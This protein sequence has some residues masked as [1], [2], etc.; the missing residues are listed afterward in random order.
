MRARWIALIACGL[1]ALGSIHLSRADGQ[2]PPPPSP[3]AVFAWSEQGM[4]STHE[5]FSSICLMPLGTT[6]RTQV[7]V[8]GD[9]PEI[10]D[11]DVT[12]TY[13]VPTH[14]RSFDKTN[15]WTHAQQ[16]F[17]VSLAPDIGRTGHGL[18]GTMTTTPG[19]LWQVTGVPVV[20]IDNAGRID[21]YPVGLVKVTGNL[22]VGESR[23]V[24]GV[25]GE[26]N[27]A[28]CHGTGTGSPSIGVLQYHD[29]FEGTD[30]MNQQPVFCA[31]CH[32]DTS[33]G[34]PGKPGISTLSHAMH[35]GML[36]AVVQSG[37]EN[38]C[39]ACHPG[40]RD[41]AQRDVHKAAGIECIN[42]H[43]DMTAMAD[44][45]R[46]PWVDLPRCENCHSGAGDEYEQPGT[47][48]KDSIGHGGVRCTSCHGSPHAIGPA[49]NPIDNQQAIALQ[50]HAGP[51]DTC[52]VCHTTTPGKK[53]F[54]R[55]EK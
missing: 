34:A 8:R 28:L 11:G 9:E 20:P 43:G 19:N 38:V 45:N 36:D 18:S 25:S 17:G 14:A 31:E 10:L 26:L 42:C 12:V 2:A 3:Y 27:C 4:I 47:L 52:A 1:A 55:V 15:F 7:I 21:P 46:I 24:L 16:L 6:I 22:G 5:D 53:F 37:L 30:L 40:I 48:Y 44:T 35:N 13:S 29:A 39:L 33:I 32:A 51:I 49:T 50:G 54:H 23:P 41:E